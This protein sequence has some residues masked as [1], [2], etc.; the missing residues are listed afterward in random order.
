MDERGVTARPPMLTVKELMA[1]W[2]VSRTTLWREVKQGRLKA[3]RLRG[4]IR[5]MLS[6]VESYERKM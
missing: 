3:S 6:D 1:R 5:F 2:S 4:S